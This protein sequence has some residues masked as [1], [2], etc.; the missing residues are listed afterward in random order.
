MAIK[1]SGTEVIND[2]RQL[3]NIT[4]T[5]GKSSAFF[6]SASAI[7]T[8]I[9]FTTPFM[10]ST[11]SAATTFSV[12]GEAAGKSAILCL[13][14]SSNS[15]TPTFPSS[16]NWEDGT[17]PTWSTYRKWQIHMIYHSS[18]RID[19][20]GIGFDA[21]SSQPTESISL[22]GTTSSP[23]YHFDMAG[24]DNYPLIMGWTFGS[25]GN[26][27]K[28]EYIYNV[29]GGGTYL[30]TSSQWNNITPSQTY[31]IRVTNFGGSHNLS[32]ADSDTINSWIALSSDRTFRVRD[33]TT[34]LN[35]YADR[36]AVIKVEISPNSNGS[37]ISAT[38]YY[39]I[40]WSG[41]A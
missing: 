31:Y 30:H 34:P 23:V 10:T 37:P 27:Y 32:T 6:P 9:N 16:F 1:V 7:T 17:E 38:G 20:V 24:G 29:G 40:Y 8:T 26:I 28:Y 22:S 2:Q 33:A 35:S 13:D 14:T 39:N 21:Q 12:S 4:D 3:V 36:N 15:Y 41:L 19:A 11:L 25:D 5:E 18:N